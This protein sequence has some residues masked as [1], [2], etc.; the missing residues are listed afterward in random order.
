MNKFIIT[1][2]N[3]TADKLRLMGFIQIPSNDNN[4]IFMN[5]NTIKINFNNIDKTKICFSNILHI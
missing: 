5:N 4:F 3:E 1:N 2:D